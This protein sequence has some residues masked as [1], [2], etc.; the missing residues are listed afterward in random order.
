MQHRDWRS[1]PNAQSIASLRERFPVE[2]TVDI[3]L[4]S[5]LE[6]R[7]FVAGTRWDGFP[8]SLQTSEVSLRGLRPHGDRIASG[9]SARHGRSDPGR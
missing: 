5:K 6:R 3:T 7:A 2:R 9:R 4:C 1:Q 8:G